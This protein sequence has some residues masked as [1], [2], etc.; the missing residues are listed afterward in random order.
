M[1]ALGPAY[2]SSLPPAL[3]PWGA[4]QGAA[5][6]VLLLIFPWSQV[7]VT[8]G[9]GQAWALNS[10]TA[11]SYLLTSFASLHLSLLSSVGLKGVCPLRWWLERGTAHPLSPGRQDTDRCCLGS[12]EAHL[13]YFMA[14]SK[15]PGGVFWKSWEAPRGKGKEAGEQEARRKQAWAEAAGEGSGTRPWPEA[16]AC[17]LPG[18]LNPS[19]TLP[20]CRGGGQAPSRPQWPPH[21][22]CPTGKLARPRP[23]SLAG[24]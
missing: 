13:H 7:T 8:G 11:R 23:V 12:P 20:N 5:T 15:F 9:I 1:A 18:A 19:S 4:Q 3:C 2:G 16:L 17:G 24:W 21:H 6:W 14:T 22:W 10:Q